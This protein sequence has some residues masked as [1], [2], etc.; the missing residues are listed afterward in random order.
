MLFSLSVAGKYNL[1]IP[2]II[3]FLIF[4][5]IHTGNVRETFFRFV[6]KQNV[7]NADSTLFV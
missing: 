4:Q 7:D 1:K 2:N 6:L 3:H 5:D